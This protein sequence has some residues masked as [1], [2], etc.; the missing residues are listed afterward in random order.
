MEIEDVVRAIME[1]PEDDDA[2]LEYADLIEPADEEHASCIRSMIS[3]S[4]RRRHGAPLLFVEEASNL[5][6][7]RDEEWARN[8]VRFLPRTGLS[9]GRTMARGLFFDRGFP[10]E[11]AIH[12][13]VFLE[14]ADLLF[15]LAPI[16]HVRFTEPYG[17][18]TY[19]PGPVPLREDG[20]PTPFPLDEILA[21]PQLSRLDSFGFADYVKET[22]LP[23]DTWARIA[24]CP[25]LTR[26]LALD[27]GALFLRPQ[28]AKALAEGV[29]T[30]KMLRIEPVTAARLYGER[31]WPE[32]DPV[33]G[34][35]TV[36]TVHE[37][38]RELEAKLGYIPWL[39][40]S[41]CPSSIYDLAYHVAQG[42]LPKYPPGTPQMK[43]W[44]EIPIQIHPRVREW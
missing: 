24:A 10:T 35:C 3:D 18:D 25:H 15:R 19:L 13:Y 8:L 12:P 27:A 41:H 38:G 11:I 32:I 42:T 20:T 29:L 7:R 21:M 26:C 2:R 39:H 22:M 44:Y 34:E 4:I 37:I 6:R 1:N 16:R 23:D 36:T 14:Y 40:S 5:L 33:H 28:D 30:S 17:Q 43:E 31:E 9:E